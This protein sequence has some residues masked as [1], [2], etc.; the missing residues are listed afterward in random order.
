MSAGYIVNEETGCWEWLGKP[1][2]SGY[3]LIHRHG[4]ACL[5]H[6]AAYEDTYGEIPPGFIVHHKCGT[7]LCVNPDHLEVQEHRDHVAAHWAEKREKRVRFDR[8]EIEIDP[9]LKERLVQ[10]CESGKVT[11]GSLVDAALRQYLTAEVSA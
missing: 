6:R 3:G 7:R 9:A 5:V 11:L 4:R 2:R 10:R 8:L 1:N